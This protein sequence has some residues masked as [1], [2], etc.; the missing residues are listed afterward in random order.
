MDAE[1]LFRQQCTT[2]LN[3]DGSANAERLMNLVVETYRLQ[4]GKKRAA[5]DHSHLLSEENTTLKRSLVATKEDLAEQQR[6]FGIVLDNLPQG[7]SVF[8]AEQRLI[9]CNTRFRQ[10]FGFS[11][12]A[13]SPGASL[14][15]LIS[16]IRGTE[17]IEKKVSRLRAATEG[18]HI[19][20]REWI[21]EDGRTIQSVITVLP[22]GSNIS[23]HADV[24]E[25]RKAAE[26]IAYL[27]HHDPL[28]GLP[29]RISLRERIDAALAACKPDEQIALV[30][31]NLDRFK[32]INNTLGVSAGDKILRQVA[33]R[34][35]M[36]AG[37]NVLAR[38]G[39]DEFAI[40]QSGR[41][42]PWNVT[43]LADQ[44]RRELSEPFFRGDK[45]V[46]LSVSMGIAISPQDGIE[47]DTLLKY[48]GV[49]LSHAKSS[50]GKGERFFTAEMEAQIEAR[51]TLEADLRK[52]IEGEEFELHYQPLYD[53]GQQKICGFEALLRWNHPTRGRVPPMEFIP[54]AE[55][56]GLVVDI[57]RWVIRRACRDAM[58]WPEDIKVAVNVS[59]IQFTNSDLPSDVAASLAEAGLPANRLEI[60]ITESVLMENLDEALPVLHALK[61]SGIRIGMDDFG[62]GYSS[63]SYLRRFPFDKI[64]I[65][66]SFVNGIVEDKE[67]FAIMRAIILLG[68]ALGMR[69]TVEGV[70]T[71]EQLAMLQREACDEIQGYHISP[72]RPAV[73]VPYLLAWPQAHPS[74]RAS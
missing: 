70:E 66:K 46:E 54:L 55:E 47:T 71:A 11:V 24:T 28:T 65:D 68:D 27:A 42:Q 23:I 49:A 20:H 58:D 69:V 61:Q 4:A 18:G 67:A 74:A 52:A 26:R 41:Q 51:H 6:L 37:G 48:A 9:V 17:R 5:E 60:E 56:V 1:A 35:R 72:P 53:L 2:A 3:E 32:S 14:K 12:E 30:H 50:G 45:A 59:A 8:D 39:S 44:I 16:M 63:L 7:L 64:K 38:L 10:V 22:D 57:G 25:D 19:R 62:T 40:L 36:S 73:D 15:T 31:L 21:M 13:A 33:E 43:A 29:N 34:I